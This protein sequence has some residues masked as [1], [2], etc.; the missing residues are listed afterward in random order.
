MRARHLSSLSLSA[1]IL[2]ATAPHGIAAD[3]G[4]EPGVSGSVELG[5]GYASDD[6]WTL[7][8]YSGWNEDSAKLIGDIDYRLWRPDAIA[9]G[10]VDYVQVFGKDLGLDTREL[11]LVFGGAGNYEFGLS[12]DEQLRAGN[13]SGRTPY[14][15][16]DTLNL[17]PDW[18]ASN[19]TS[20]M[21]AFDSTAGEFDQDLE[22]KRWTIELEKALVPGWDLRTGFSSEEKTGTLGQG[23]ALY[24][25]ASNGHAALLPR[26]VDFTTNEFD[27]GLG[28]VCNGIS[29]DVSYLYSS[30]ENDASR[31][32]WQNPY[33][34][35][36]GAGVDYPDG[37]GQMALEPDN[38]MQRLRVLGSYLVSS[39]LR[40]TVDGSWAESTQ[41]D[42]LLPYTVNPNLLV[43]EDLPRDDFDG[44]VVT[45]VFNAA[46]YYRPFSKLSLE[47]KYRY[48]DR[49]YDSPRDGY[50]YVR[51]DAWNQPDTM[52]TVYNTTHDRTLNRYDLEGTYRL[53]WATR[54]SASYRYEDIK[55]RNAAV[56]ETEEDVYRL[57]LSNGYWQGVQLRLEGSYS[58]RAASTYRWDQSYYAL[59]DAEL[60][61]LTPDSQRYSNHPLLFQ[62][63]LAN[64][65]QWEARLNLGYVPAENWSLNL[66]LLHSENDYDKSELGLLEDESDHATLSLGLTPSKTVNLSAYIGYDY[67]SN[68]QA[69][70][71][72]RGGGEKNAFEIYPPLPQASDPSRNWK[73][74]GED[75]TLTFG[76]NLQWQI[77][78]R[79]DAEVD[80]SYVD[81]TG[82][83]SFS[84]AGATDLDATSLPDLENE[85]HDFR[86]SAQYKMQER[87]SLKFDYR[88]YHFDDD[89]WAFDGVGY[90]TMNK[91][92]WSGQQNP[93]DDIHFFQ[94]S[95]IYRLEQ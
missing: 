13:F 7:G 50:R 66:D 75:E 69:N 38:E 76:V 19:N 78:E 20:G 77:T 51:G 34:N 84:T 86:V 58:D 68:H 62:Y 9:G 16:S 37:F 17:P 21:I 27:L 24:I 93:D 12:Y 85:Q 40:F 54:L 31:L 42:G 45:G 57:V 83:Q 1:C 35:V 48:E 87:L 56:R 52:F 18:V 60:I 8:R 44:E 23:G 72:F 49:D 80:Y 64:R 61:N 74:E 29:L 15:G 47:A 94:A 32:S 92:L 39:Q 79:L 43:E 63:H 2:A 33:D 89:Y 46:A 6:N 67:Y 4:P 95:V 55:R 30:F 70:R 11:D 82:E 71:A 91:V 10:M 36:F 88:F 90:D 5:V 22:R 59:L 65:E 26:P 25:D 3:F 41:D 14:S 81:S 28:Y 73:T 53:P